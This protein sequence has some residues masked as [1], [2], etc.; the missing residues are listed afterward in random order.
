M[1]KANE[2]VLS[3]DGETFRR[4]KT[5]FDGILNRTIGNMQM[6]GASDASITLKLDISITKGIINID[7][8]NRDYNKPSFKHQIN[9]VLQIKDKATGQLAGEIVLEWDDDAE[10]FVVRPVDDGQASLFDDDEYETSDDDDVIDAKALPAPEQDYESHDDQT[11]EEKAFD[12][13]LGF[14]ERHL[15]VVESNGVY[16]VRTCDTNEVV[17]SSGCEE[18]SLFWIDPEVAAKHVGDKLLCYM[19]SDDA[20]N[21]SGVAID[22]TSCNKTIFVMQA[23]E[24][25]SFELPD[26]E[27]EDTNVDDSDNAETDEVP[28]DDGTDDGDYD[29]DSPEEDE[30]E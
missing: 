13:M 26:M 17:L 1:S 20:K 30:E 24:S 7:G 15:T 9:S 11:M 8:V 6:K 19:F 5:D 18:G 27:D 10:K 29:Y 2:M 12:V 23:P 4:L 16:T 22:C 3:L 28:D 14:T 21:I 25:M